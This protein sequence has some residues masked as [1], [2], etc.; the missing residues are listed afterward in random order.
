MNHETNLV[1][2]EIIDSIL[3]NAIST[4]PV[5]SK[6]DYMYMI[7]NPKTNITEASITVQCDKNGKEK[8]AFC[9]KHLKN[10]IDIIKINN[11][12]DAKFVNDACKQR[13]TAQAKEIAKINRF[14]QRFL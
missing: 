10:C 1:R 5:Q 13:L 9:I 7:Y 14:N 6:T 11:P 3:S 8:S 12:E 4:T 2:G